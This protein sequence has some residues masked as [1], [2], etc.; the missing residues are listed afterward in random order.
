M[1]EEV[2]RGV[3][4]AVYDFVW[5]TAHLYKDAPG[6]KLACPQRPKLESY[7]NSKMMLFDFMLESASEEAELK[8]IVKN[9]ME[10]L[11]SNF[12]EAVHGDARLLSFY[13][14]R[15]EECFQVIADS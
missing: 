9:F 7:V 3:R 14:Q 15:K 13:Q 8:G 6:G 12:Q 5:Q 4:G 10:G 1:A 11:E 2:K